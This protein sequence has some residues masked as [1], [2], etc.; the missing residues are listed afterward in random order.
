M[1]KQ[2]FYGWKKTAQELVAIGDYSCDDPGLLALSPQDEKY[3]IIENMM[4]TT[5]QTHPC[6]TFAKYNIQKIELIK[7]T[8]QFRAYNTKRGEIAQSQNN[9]ANQRWLFHGS[10]SARTIALQGFDKAYSNSNGMFGKGIYFAHDSSKSNQYT[11]CGPTKV[12]NN[13]HST[14]SACDCVRE[15]LY[16]RVILGKFSVETVAKKEDSRDGFHSVKAVPGD[17]LKYAEYV[18]YEVDQALPYYLIT[19]T[20]K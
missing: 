5:I 3:K 18:V 13:G 12:C 8:K 2:Q 1:A 14:Y 10:P 19:Y 9:H 6:G 16:C 17:Q 20:T 7:N 15:M 11:I 4:N